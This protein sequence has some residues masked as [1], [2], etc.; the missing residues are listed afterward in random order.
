MNK[1]T[2]HMSNS[3]W[4]LKSPKHP[5]LQSRLRNQ[6]V[7]HILDVLEAALTIC[8]HI[9]ASQSRGSQNKY[10]RQKFACRKS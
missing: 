9:H 2:E 1:T 4:C 5:W 8:S 7:G 6:Q 10:F 3:L